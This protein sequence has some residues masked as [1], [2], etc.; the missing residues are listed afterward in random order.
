MNIKVITFGLL[1]S[2]LS[3]GAQALEKAQISEQFSALFLGFKLSALEAQPLINDPAIGDKGLTGEV[4]IEKTKAHYKKVTGKTFAFS[5]DPSLKKAQQNLFTSIKHVMKKVAPII[6]RKGL[7]FKGMI[8]AIFARKLAKEFTERM[9]GEMSFKFTTSHKLLRSKANKADDWEQN[10]MAN[11]L[12]KTAGKNSKAYAEV[13]D[14]QFRWMKPVYHE[15][16][17]MSCHG[18]P[19]G[20]RDIT[21]T[22]KEGAKVGDLSGAFSIIMSE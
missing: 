21:G 22:V 15:P 5:T 17:C 10:V 7:G 1:L 6:N 18:G 8:T 20:E 14:G 12:D 9:D 4:M 19:K 16:V 2:W 11:I 3:I 13:I